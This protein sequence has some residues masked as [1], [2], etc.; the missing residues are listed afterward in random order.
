MFQR[1]SHAQP[2]TDRDRQRDR[3]RQTD[4]QTDRD[5]QTHRHTHRER[6]RQRQRERERSSFTMGVCHS[7]FDDRFER[8]ATDLGPFLEK[9]GMT[10]NEAK[11]FYK[12]FEKVDADLE[13]GISVDE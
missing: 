11:K 2:H 4:R 10:D 6:E 5:R 3:Q 13:G 1:D 12:I 9:L 8:A 7:E